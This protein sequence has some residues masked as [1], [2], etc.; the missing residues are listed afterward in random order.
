MAMPI[1]NTTFHILKIFYPRLLLVGFTV[2][3]SCWSAFTFF[4][5]NTD[6]RKYAG[7]SLY[8][9]HHEG[10]KKHIHDVVGKSAVCYPHHEGTKFIAER[11]HEEINRA[12]P[13]S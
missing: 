1:R 8:Y 6:S 12:L 4:I 2:L 9:P 13:T 3:V 10:A 11:L 7:I 5:S